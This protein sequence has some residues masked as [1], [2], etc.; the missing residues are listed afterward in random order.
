MIQD[1]KY[2]V[3]S[4]NPSDYECPDG[5]L[6][7]SL[8]LVPEDGS[9]HPVM[10]PKTI[11]ALDKGLAVVH[12]HETNA[13]K[14][15]VVG[16]SSGNLFWID[17]D[18]GQCTRKPLLSTG[19]SVVTYQINSIGNVVVVLTEAG[20]R[21]LLWK[22]E[23]GEYKDLGS[24][25]P[26]ISISFGL[27]RSLKEHGSTTVQLPHQLGAGRPADNGQST[28]ENRAAIT[29]QLLGLVNEAIAVNSKDGYFTYPFFVRYALRLYD[30]SLTR[31]SAPVLMPCVS[32]TNP[33]VGCSIPDGLYSEFQAGVYSYRFRL[34]YAL[35]ADGTGSTPEDAKEH[36]SD[37]ADI[38]KSVDIFVSAPIYTYDQ[39]GECD[40][41]MHKY[42]N[43]FSLSWDGAFSS[44]DHA[45]YKWTD[46]THEGDVVPLPERDAE[47]VFQDIRDCGTF[48]LLDS[49]PIGELATKRTVINVEESYLSSL[50][51]R[52]QM[53]DDYGSHDT[54]IPMY[55]HV[56]NSRLN[57]ANIG[58]RYFGGF[59]PASMFCFCGLAARSE[60]YVPQSPP[61]ASAA[62]P[63]SNDNE[64]EESPAI[65]VPLCY[66]YIR[67]PSS[68]EV[69]V[70]NG[71]MSMMNI[72][73][74]SPLLYMFYPDTN[75][76]K[77]RLYVEAGDNMWRVAEV[78]L[79]PHDFLNGAYYF[80]GWD[81][82]DITS[83]EL[84]DV[85]PVP[86][87]TTV[88]V[89][90]KLYCSEVNNPFFFPLS[91]II[92]VG[93]GRILGISS[94][95][96]ALSQGQFGQFPLYAFTTDGVWALEISSTGT[97]SARQ[98]ITRDVCVNADSI[99]QIDS[100]VLFATAR[101]IMLVSGSQV[102]CLSDSLK[103]EDIFTPTD[104]PKHDG[105]LKVFNSKATK[106]EQLAAADIAMLP[107]ADFLKQCR[108]IY[109]YVGQRIVVYNPNVRYA[110]VF[111]LKSKSWGMMQCD[112]KSSV[113][114][115]PEALAMDGNS[116]LVNFSL[117]DAEGITALV[118][119]RPFKL[120]DP[121]VFKTVD[122]VIQRGYFKRG[123]VAQV[124]YGSNDLFNWLP[125]WSSVDKYMRGFR[126]SPYKF[127]R[128]A[129]IC[130]LDKSESVLGCSVQFEVRMNDQPR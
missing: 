101:G 54:L 59:D 72:S 57:L 103:A 105:L 88:D 13:F 55:S 93:I 91:G 96:K 53:S 119:T 16:D 20:M 40:E 51:A 82:V 8:G 39:N 30:G 89:G 69:Q 35:V 65:N 76:Y 102:L 12:I 130:N 49:I 45:V 67:D 23:T 100:A 117:A 25:L 31:H 115:Y 64:D 110:Y 10:P 24:G 1:I 74:G 120:G 75:A 3:Y 22:S 83:G 108:M 77:A 48:Y 123:H 99:T 36:L 124:L 5:D 11:L 28:R 73:D 34:D 111:S 87:Q 116:R 60:V 42:K 41:P 66:V 81:G 38:V 19:S 58:K 32:G 47:D 15:Y 121:G 79:V 43:L 86:A 52:E 95:A 68:G 85:R 27:R 70:Y 80:N 4:A 118:V 50:V 21:Y 78:N 104:L 62:S 129:L 122:T 46:V 113:N 126:G 56:Y 84:T 107:F 37:F 97:Y 33:F 17:A 106:D 14:H 44:S 9:L 92:T 61:R 94:A 71:S 114:S 90:S 18:D 6:A 98:P 26:E 2:N 109:D 125:V 29:E 63:G 7:L 127:F 128:L 112:I